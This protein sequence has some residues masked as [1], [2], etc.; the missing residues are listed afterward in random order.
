MTPDPVYRYLSELRASLR[1]P[2]A[3]RILAEAEDHLREGIAAGQAA[4]RT[5]TEAQ[6]A[7]ISAFGPV[8]AVARAHQT[9]RGKAVAIAADVTMAA[10]KLGWLFLLAFIVSY[11]VTLTRMKLTG[12]PAGSQVSY[13]NQTWLQPAI[14]DLT[15][16][17]AYHL[18]RRLRRRRGQVQEMLFGGYFPL[19]AAVFF[20]ATAV[21]MASLVR[22]VTGPAILA[23]LAAGYALRMSRTFRRQRHSGMR[24][25]GAGSHCALPE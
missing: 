14:V 17:A 25:N 16:F 22:Q 6:E 2:D 24:H 12:S 20:A 18:V 11:L 7:A 8:R 10:S 3:D 15:L 13:L 4:G 1:G 21:G 19:V 5:E 9:R 23:A